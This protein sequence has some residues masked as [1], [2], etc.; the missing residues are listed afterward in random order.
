MRNDWS[1][2]TDTRHHW[3]PI[4]LDKTATTVSSNAALCYPTGAGNQHFA[5]GPFA[6]SRW[7]ASPPEYLSAVRIQKLSL[8]TRRLISTLDKIE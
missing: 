1:S 7:W 4:A 6:D 3:Q 8:A 2:Q 5:L